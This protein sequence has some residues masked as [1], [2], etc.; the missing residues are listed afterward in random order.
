MRSGG[1]GAKNYAGTALW[2][3]TM[4]PHVGGTAADVGGILPIALTNFEKGIFYIG[5]TGLRPV[6]PMVWPFS[7]VDPTWRGARSQVPCQLQVW[8]WARGRFYWYISSYAAKCVIRSNGWVWGFVAKMTIAAALPPTQQRPMVGGGGGD[9]QMRWGT[10]P[11]APVTTFVISSP[12]LEASFTAQDL[13]LKW[14]GV[15]QKRPPNIYFDGP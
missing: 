8:E 10:L 5:R 2:V 3:F 13:A 12:K 14:V 6:R 15:A 4:Q 7:P 11:G 1:P 9:G